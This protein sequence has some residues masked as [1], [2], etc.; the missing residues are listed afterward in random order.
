VRPVVTST[1]VLVLCFEGRPETTPRATVDVYSR[2]DGTRTAT[3]TA[4][5]AVGPITDV[6]RVSGLI[7]APGAVVLVVQQYDP[8]RA[9]V[10]AL[11]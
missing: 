2:S 3:I 7:P 4:T 1:S 8:G 11:G 10:A 9:V 6:S 5:D